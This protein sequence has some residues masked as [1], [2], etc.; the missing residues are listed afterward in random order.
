MESRPDDTTD[1]V[2]WIDT[3]KMICDC[4]TKKMK[5]D[6]L[7]EVLDSNR[8]DPRQ[9]EEALAQKE[10]RII[11]RQNSADAKKKRSAEPADSDSDRE[12]VTPATPTR[13]PVSRTAKP[14][15]RDT[16][17]PQLVSKDLRPVYPFPY[18][19]RNRW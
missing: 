15:S 9:D 18:S 6:Y 3:P 16:K 14:P 2:I 19:N 11:L 10:H 17:L 1:S 8:W 12:I 5:P 7:R 13:S 4:M